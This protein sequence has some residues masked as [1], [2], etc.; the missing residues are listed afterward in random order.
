MTKRDGWFSTDKILRR[1]NSREEGGRKRRG[2]KDRK[3]NRVSKV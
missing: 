3:V 1:K 2:E